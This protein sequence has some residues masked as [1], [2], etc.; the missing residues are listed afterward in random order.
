MDAIRVAVTFATPEL[1]I[2]ELEGFL[3]TFILPRK[4]PKKNR[5][6][7]LDLTSPDEPMNPRPKIH[8][9]A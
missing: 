8:S 4:I 6:I 7:Y 3:Y 1:H 5:K 2:C 9:R